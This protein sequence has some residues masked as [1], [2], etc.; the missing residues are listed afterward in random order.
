MNPVEQKAVREGLTLGLGVGPKR[1]CG[2]HREGW[3]LVL[4]WGAKTSLRNVV[5]VRLLVVGPRWPPVQWATTF[6]E[7]V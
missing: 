4:M 3:C 2:A 5:W 6:A 1:F 7:S